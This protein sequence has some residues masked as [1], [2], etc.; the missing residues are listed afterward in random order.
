MMLLVSLKVFSSFRNLK[1]CYKMHLSFPSFLPSSSHGGGG[2]R[3]FKFPMVDK[4]ENKNLLEN[5]ATTM[6]C[7]A[8]NGMS[9]SFFFRFERNFDVQFFYKSIGSVPMRSTAN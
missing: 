2:G 7:F 8:T 9:V 4:N 1:L 5:S 3:V 6:Q